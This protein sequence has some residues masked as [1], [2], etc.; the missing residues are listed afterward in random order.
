[1]KIVNLV[2]TSIKVMSWVVTNMVLLTAGLW[3]MDNVIKTATGG[4]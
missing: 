2:E 4:G 1:M 3:A